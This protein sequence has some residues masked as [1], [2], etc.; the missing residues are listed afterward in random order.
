VCKE[1]SGFRLKLHYCTSD[2]VRTSAE[3]TSYKGITSS[4]LLEP[5]LLLLLVVVVVVVVVVY[6][7]QFLMPSVVARQW[8]DLRSEIICQKNVYKQLVFV[9]DNWINIYQSYSSCLPVNLPVHMKQL[10]SHWTD[11]EMC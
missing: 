1:V 9:I 6:Q 5:L 10:V 7:V 4:I 3:S 11:F 8:L 2:L